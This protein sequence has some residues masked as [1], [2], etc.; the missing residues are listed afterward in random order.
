MGEEFESVRFCC[1]AYGLDFESDPPKFHWKY[2]FPCK[3]CVVKF[4]GMINCAGFA[5][6]VCSCVHVLMPLRPGKAMGSWMVG[7]WVRGVFSHIL[8]IMANLT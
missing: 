8:L 3:K 2:V 5:C 6:C 7:W 4:S 1:V